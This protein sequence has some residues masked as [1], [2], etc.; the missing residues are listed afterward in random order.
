MNFVS[1]VPILPLWFSRAK[2]R[3]VYWP[4]PSVNP[5]SYCRWR[6]PICAA[7]ASV[8]LSVMLSRTPDTSLPEAL[9]TWPMKSKSAVWLAPLLVSP[10]AEP[11]IFTEI[12]T[13]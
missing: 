13:K 1:N 4:G 6:R 8:S 7:L 11:G 2:K 5:A 9:R 12:G 3:K 10:T